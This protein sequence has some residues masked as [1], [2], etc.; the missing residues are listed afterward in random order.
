MSNHH[1]ENW[2][3]K[4][5]IG[6]SLVAGGIFFLY[7][8]LTQLK[9]KENWI[10]YGGVSAV[11]ITLGVFFLS[12]SAIHKVKSDMIKKQKMKQQSG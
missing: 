2:I 1:Y 8:S 6:L 3:F 11:A 9:A 7:Y 12:M 4:T 10:F 5:V